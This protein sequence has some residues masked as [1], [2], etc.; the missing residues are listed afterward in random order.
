MKVRTQ[1]INLILK[2]CIYMVIYALILGLGIF[3]RCH[4]LF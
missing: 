4:Y 2:Y 3:S 1:N